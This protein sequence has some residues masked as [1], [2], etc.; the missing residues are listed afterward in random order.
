[1][2]LTTEIIERIENDF[3]LTYKPFTQFKNSGELWDRCIAT[4]GNA[5]IM[6]KIIFCNDYLKVP[7]VKVF[8][9]LNADI[10]QDL[11]DNDKKSI[12]AFWGFVF[13][14]VFNYKNQ[15][16][17]AVSTQGIKTA[18]YFFDNKDVVEVRDVR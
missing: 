17:I 16:S 6:N 7:P 8:A 11:S 12:G 4:V 14:F 9:K 3:V 13:K 5:D 18:T 15:K 2:F 10:M 1:M